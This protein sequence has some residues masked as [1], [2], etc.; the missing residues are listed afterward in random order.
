M[1]GKLSIA[2]ESVP[3]VSPI[4]AVNNVSSQ[5]SSGNNV[6]N[7]NEM[8][9]VYDATH[10]LHAHI[11]EPVI[12]ASAKPPSFL[13][14]KKTRNC[15]LGIVLIT[16]L[17]SI[18]WS[19]AGSLY[20]SIPFQ[21][22]EPEN[23]ILKSM[24]LGSIA[25]QI[26]GVVSGNNPVTTSLWINATD[27][28]IKD[29]YAANEDFGI[30]VTKIETVFLEDLFTEQEDTGVIEI[31]YS[32]VFNFY[33]KDNS[34]IAE[35]FALTPFST[36]QGKSTYIASLKSMNEMY[37]KVYDIGDVFTFTSYPSGLPTISMKP[38]VSTFPTDLTSLYPTL[39]PSHIPSASFLPTMAY[40]LT[41]WSLAVNEMSSKLFSGI[42]HHTMAVSDDLDCIVESSVGRV[43][44]LERNGSSTYSLFQ[45]ITTNSLYKYHEVEIGKDGTVLII[46][47]FG[48]NNTLYSLSVYFREDTKQTFKIQQRLEGFSIDDLFGR[49]TSVTPNGLILVVLSAPRDQ[50]FYNHRFPLIH[51]FSRDKLES[52]FFF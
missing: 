45:N 1:K 8:Q 49:R 28:H 19:I 7:N 33:T 6:E 20:P 46:T 47:N 44:V 41:R 50:S 32:Q 17:V 13:Q 21:M 38:S 10:V 30:I 39:F 52:Q 15:V 43:S 22:I 37:S 48:L 11:V 51:I 14:N 9:I 36:R 5:N 34:T 4:T 3:E 23:F 2:H 40:S 24:N 12:F 31:R 18:V 29:F 16:S 26:R 27:E 25:M 35:N 42:N